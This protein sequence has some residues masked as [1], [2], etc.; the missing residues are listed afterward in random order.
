MALSVYQS[1]QGES[2]GLPNGKKKNKEVVISETLLRE[3]ESE[4]GFSNWSEQAISD[5]EFR[6]GQQWT[7][8][9]KRELE[10]RGQAAMVHNVIHPKVEQAKSILT[11]ND[12]RFMATAAEDSDVDLAKLATM[13][14]EH[15]WTQSRGKDALKQAIDDYYVKGR[16]VLYAYYDPNAG[17][18]NGDV[19][20]KD[21]ETLRVY[22]DP[23]AKDRYWRDAQHVIVRHLM[24]ESQVREIAPD[25]NLKNAAQSSDEMMPSRSYTQENEVALSGD[26]AIH[27]FAPRY[28]VIER[29][30]K[31]H[32][33]YYRLVDK[34]TGNMEYY[35]EEEYKEFK[36]GYGIVIEGGNQSVA[37]AMGDDLIEAQELY[38]TLLTQAAMSGEANPPKELTGKEESGDPIIFHLMQGEPMEDGTPTQPIPMFGAEHDG[39]GVIA[40]STSFIQPIRRDL[41]ENIAYES[42]SYKQVRYQVVSS[43][44]GLLINDAILPIDRPPVVPIMNGFNRN[45]FPTSDVFHVRD[46]QKQINYTESKI[47]AHAASAAS[48]GLLL[49]RGSVLDREAFEAKVNR[50]GRWVEEYEAEMGSPTVVAPTPLPSEFYNKSQRD[51]QMIEMILGLYAMQQGEVAQAPQTFRGTLAMDEFAQRRMKSKLD[52][53][54]GS[55]NEL[56]RV[57]ISMYQAYVTDERVLRIVNPST[58]EIQS[59]Q[60]NVLKY[61]D[62]GNV[63]GKFNDL[64]AMNVDI[65]VIS[66]STL[67][68]NRFAL[69]DYY[70]QFY[71][72]GLIDQVEVLKKSEVFD[73]EGILGRTGYIKGLEGQLAAMQEEIKKLK[74]DLQTADREAVQAR[75]RTEVEKFKASLAEPKAQIRAARDVYKQRSNDAVRNFRKQI[76]DAENEVLSQTPPE[77][78]K[79][80]RQ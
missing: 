52:D 5:D 35:S 28:E 25:I 33:K 51:I 23:N 47:I 6:N 44:G 38:F 3:Y 59:A 10:R 20:I 72:A 71:Q 77:P 32:K 2:G 17:G 13:L 45:P 29:F 27:S 42:F 55:L 1:R 69:L 61:D 22:C 18:G 78:N 37:V 8:E 57:V 7:G 54:E 31:V 56:A 74:G 34:G 65:R 79:P 50:P 12:P 40:G 43:V 49:P 70:L 46:L 53:I 19:L 39:E 11:T 66:G 26:P 21:V 68:T 9:Q 80:I 16:G 30:T 41:L 4:N 76:S 67:P 14:L 15:T 36:N 48:V 63:I 64:Q 58:K 24:T 75:K 62:Y 73:I 60:V